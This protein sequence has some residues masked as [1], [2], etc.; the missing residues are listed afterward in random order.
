MFFCASAALVSMADTSFKDVT[1]SFF[2]AATTKLRA[3]RRERASLY[4]Y[5]VGWR[6][7]NIPFSACSGRSEKRKEF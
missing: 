5:I 3:E 4:T 2:S 7:L 1:G 6:N